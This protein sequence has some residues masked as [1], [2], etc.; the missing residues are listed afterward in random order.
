[1]SVIM[2]SDDHDL[3]LINTLFNLKVTLLIVLTNQWI[4]V[5]SRAT[6]RPLDIDGQV[7]RRAK[8]K[9]RTP[10]RRDMVLVKACLT[11]CMP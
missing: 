1:M 11:Q 4:H 6:C 2:D 9:R 5:Y 10:R 7:K 8:L 3:E